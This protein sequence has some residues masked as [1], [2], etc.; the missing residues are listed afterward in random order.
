MRYQFFKLWILCE[1]NVR[2]FF[3]EVFDENFV[4]K[5]TKEIEKRKEKNMYDN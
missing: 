3:D 5:N 2:A 4:I 1:F